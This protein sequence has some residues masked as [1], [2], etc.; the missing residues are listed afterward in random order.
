MSLVNTNSAIT[1]HGMCLRQSGGG[2]YYYLLK[3]IY[4][5]QAY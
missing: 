3:G 4:V 1:M 5:N 2:S